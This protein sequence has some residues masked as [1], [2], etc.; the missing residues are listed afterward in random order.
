MRLRFFGV[1]CA[2]VVMACGGGDD[3]ASQPS[4]GDSTSTDEGVKSDAPITDD[5]AI[6]TDGGPTTSGG[7]FATP[8]P[9]GSVTIKLVP[10]EAVTAGSMQLVTFGLPFARKS[11]TASDLAKV[12]VLIDGAEVSA[13]VGLLTPWRHLVDASD[14]GKFVRVA[15]IQLRH[16]FA[17]VAPKD[18][19]VEWGSVA[20]TKDV[21]T[22]TRVRDGWHRVNTGTFATADN[23]DE[24]NVYALLPATRL[25]AG[26]LKTMP[27]Q[28]FD[29]SVGEARD[30]PA[31][32][33]ATE[34]YPAFREQEHASKN[35]FY[36]AIGEDDPAVTTANRCAYKTDSE[37]WLYDRASAFFNVHFRS[38]HLKP[39][40]EAV[41]ASV[42]Y[43]S[44]LYPPGTIP[45]KAVG[46]FIPKNPSPSAY[47]GANGVMY[48]Y[49]ESL[50]YAHWLTGDDELAKPI[51]WVSKAQEDSTDEP[52]KWSTTAGYTERHVGFRLLAHAIAFEVLGDVAYK[53]GGA[54]YKALVKT[55]ADNLIWHQDGG[56]GSVPAMRIDGALWKYGRQQGDGPETA[57][58][59]SPWLSA[60]VVDAMVRVYAVSART[61]VAHFLRRMGTFLKAATDKLADDEY[62]AS[63]ELRKVDYV[64]LIDGNRY[65]PD[66]A[67]GEHALEVSASIATAYYF[68]KLTGMPDPTLKTHATEVYRTYDFSV[69]FW[70]RPTAPAS[71]ASAYRLQVGSCR[72][73]GWEHRPSAS[74]SWAL[75]D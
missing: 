40:R 39:L 70:T 37:P 54:T 41:R 75:A 47:I 42:F 6:V 27:M 68:S 74:L 1:W 18:I 20:R 49:S 17:T 19:V 31:T 62:G 43:A 50:A 34:H 53:S 10:T 23:V 7:F 52:Y 14:D 4:G 67:T 57:W 56:G 22:L 66:G 35:F 71:G 51:A 45:D 61:D 55:G 3:N 11:V 65:A 69:N 8:E 72:K 21:A 24:P 60:I 32:M 73:Y 25:S 29:P 15:R 5:S 30:N 59:A 28:P 16:T 12:R 46:A 2:T 63:E 36:T 48:S 9:T 13:H 26:S 64:T 38:G 44:K 58:V 33:D